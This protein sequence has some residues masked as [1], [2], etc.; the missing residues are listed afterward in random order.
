MNRSSIIALV[1]LGAILAYFLKRKG[2]PLWMANFLVK[3][4]LAG[5]FMA[6]IL[7]PARH[8]PLFQALPVAAAAGVAYLAALFLLRTFSS[9]ELRLMREGLGFVSVYFRRSPRQ[10][11]GQA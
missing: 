5:L 2:H 8:L 9:D 3:P 4:I 1:V 7:F 10:L 6:A 11:Q